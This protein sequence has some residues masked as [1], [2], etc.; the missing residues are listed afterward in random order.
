MALNLANCGHCADYACGK[1][2]GFFGFAPEA[3][4]TLDVIRAGLMA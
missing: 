1:L 3:R 2:E 4:A